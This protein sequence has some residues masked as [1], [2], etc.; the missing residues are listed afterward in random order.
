MEDTQE[1]ITLCG[2]YVTEK[3]CESKTAM[4]GDKTLWRNWGNEKKRRT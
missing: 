1:A 2:G 4:R 3:S